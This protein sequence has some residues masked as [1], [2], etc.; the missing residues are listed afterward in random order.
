[1][2]YERKLKFIVME[3][4]NLGSLQEMIE[5]RGHIPEI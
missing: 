4:C 2:D 5:D 1:M 3:Y